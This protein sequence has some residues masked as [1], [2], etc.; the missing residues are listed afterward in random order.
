MTSHEAAELMVAAIVKNPEATAKVWDKKGVRV[1]VTLYGKDIGYFE[2][3]AGEGKKAVL[4]RINKYA[5]T[6]DVL[7][8]DVIR[9]LKVEAEVASEPQRN[10]VQ[11]AKNGDVRRYATEE[12]LAYLVR[13][14]L[15]SESTA[16]NQDM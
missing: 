8:Q 3:V 12:E 1:Y 7:V 13:N 9:D 15:V 10:L 14:G 11:D 4:S 2:I 5:G 16:M 6:V